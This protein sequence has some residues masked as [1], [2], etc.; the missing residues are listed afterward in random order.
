MLSYSHPIQVLSSVLIQSIL[1]ALRPLTFYIH[2]FARRP[3]AYVK[4][5]RLQ[6]KSG[7]SRWHKILSKMET[8]NSPIMALL[9][10]AELIKQ[11]AEAVSRRSKQASLIIVR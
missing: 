5:T 9:M 6:R 3:S 2:H 1:I 8:A 10:Q 11:G 7:A 4:T